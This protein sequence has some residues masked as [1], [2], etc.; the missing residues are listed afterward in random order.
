MW[1]FTPPLCLGAPTLMLHEICMHLPLL[2]LQR[3]WKFLSGIFL[4]VIFQYVTSLFFLL[5][6]PIQIQSHG[7]VLISWILAKS[8]SNF[9]V[10][11]W[12]IHLYVI[13]CIEIIRK[14]I[15]N[16]SLA[17]LS[18]EITLTQSYKHSNHL[19]CTFPSSNLNLYVENFLMISMHFPKCCFSLVFVL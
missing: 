13:K 11:C 18:R 17:N 16:Y 4:H 7:E 5:S 1:W 15:T 2:T 14:L 10:L 8:S 19:Q 3:S 6:P 12:V 9:L